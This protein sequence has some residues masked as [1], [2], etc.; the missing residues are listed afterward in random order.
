M[1]KVKH[2]NIKDKLRM[3]FF[4][5]VVIT[6]LSFI[7]LPVQIYA[8]EADKKEIVPKTYEDLT[9]EPLPEEYKTGDAPIA[10]ITDP[11]VQLSDGTGSVTVKAD[12]SKNI[13]EQAFVTLTN[14]NTGEEYTAF[15]YEANGYETVINVPEGVYA[16]GGGLTADA[17]GRF[18]MS[19]VYFNAAPYSNTAVFVELIDHQEELKAA[20]EKKELNMQ[21]V[22]HEEASDEASS[23]VSTEEVKKAGLLNAINYYGENTYHAT[24]A[25]PKSIVISVISSLVFI[26]IGFFIYMRIKKR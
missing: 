7:V 24:K 14:M 21:V 18:R 9:G 25:D 15:L 2:S 23:E 19:E 8:S 5:V 12:I 17:A 16:T 6:I 10:T 11:G 22:P 20:E 13:H 1:Y 26:G 3:K 4:T